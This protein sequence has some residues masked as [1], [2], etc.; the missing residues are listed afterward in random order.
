MASRTRTLGKCRL[1]YFAGSLFL[2]ISA[3]YISNKFGDSIALQSS[4]LRYLILTQLG[5]ASICCICGIILG[6]NKISLRIVSFINI[7]F[8]FSPLAIYLAIV[9]KLPSADMGLVL[10]SFMTTLIFAYMGIDLYH[11]SKG[12]TSHAL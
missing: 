9:N 2:G 1:N 11:Y 12:F 5:Y 3:L 10:Y 4:P 6:I 8:V 7:C